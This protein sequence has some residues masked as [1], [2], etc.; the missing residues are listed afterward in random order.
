MRG[1]PRPPYLYQELMLIHRRETPFHVPPIPRELTLSSLIPVAD[2][3]DRTGLPS[4]VTERIHPL[5]HVSTENKGHQRNGRCRK[6]SKGEHD[7][8][9]LVFS[10]QSSIIP[11][12]SHSP[13][14]VQKNPD[15]TVSNQGLT[16]PGCTHSEPI[17][18]CEES[19]GAPVPLPGPVLCQKGP[20][21]TETKLFQPWNTNQPPSALPFA[22]TKFMSL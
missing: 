20:G 4:L 5:L 22:R 17:E 16:K 19:Q 1:S 11:Q 21:P 2:Q 12:D 18:F 6:H 14:G 15:I 9:T 8:P 3:K 13:A 10:E 7:K